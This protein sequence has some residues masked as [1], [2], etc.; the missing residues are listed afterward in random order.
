M[1]WNVYLTVFKKRTTTQL[2]R[3]EPYY[4]ILCYGIPF[5]IAIT[6]LVYKPPDQRPRI[7]GE[8]TLWCWISPEWQVLRIAAFYGPVW[9]V[10]IVTFII[11][12]LAGRVIFILRRNLRNFVSEGSTAQSRTENPVFSGAPSAL[13]VPDKTASSSPQAELELER[14]LA[15]NP[16]GGPNHPPQEVVFGTT[17]TVEV[18][19]GA[20]KVPRNDRNT[21]LTRKQRNI[22]VE[23]NTAA[24]A[25]CRCAMLFFLALVIT[26]VASLHPHHSPAHDISNNHS[27][28]IKYQPRVHPPQPRPRRLRLQLCS[29]AGAPVSGLLERRDI[30]RHD[31]ARL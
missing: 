3:L 19:S 12:L 17:Y 27:A 20:T 15:G 1:A 29:R 8:A 4:I 9:V 11:Y 30:H 31:A 22:A 13:K 16:R 6:F 14:I 28:S 2:R 26:W 5:I 24:W 7:Y 21:E 10:L 25:Y 18:E 23:A